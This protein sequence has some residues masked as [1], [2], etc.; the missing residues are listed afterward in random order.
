[1][2]TLDEFVSIAHRVVWATV[3][4]V[5]RRGRPRSRVLHPLWVR[6]GDRLTGWV[7]TRPTPLKRAHL[8]RSPHASC[9]YWDPVHD[10]AVAECAA[11]W[12]HDPAVREDVWRR[13]LDAPAPLGYDFAQIFPDG[14]QSDDAGFLRLD[15]WRIRT[16]RVVAGGPPLVWTLAPSAAASA[17]PRTNASASLA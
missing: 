17:P 10:T 13:F 2:D 14:P 6:D 7:I 5:D 11:A 8:A 16:H 4:T 15:P 1:M 3:A 12:E 9:S